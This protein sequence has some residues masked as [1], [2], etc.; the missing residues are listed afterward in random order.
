M[1]NYKADGWDQVPA[2]IVAS[3]PSLSDDQLALVLEARLAQR[4]HVITVN[5]TAE[6]APWADVHYFGDYLAVKH[7][8]PLLKACRGTWWTGDRAAAERHRCRYVRSTDRK[9][10]GD[11]RVH[12]NGNSGAQALNL[13]VL[14][15]AKRIVLLGFDMR[16]VKGRAHWF[17]QHPAPL[18]Q[19]QQYAEWLHKFKAVAEDA[20]AMNVE[21]TNCTPESALKWFETGEL[22]EVLR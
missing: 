21:V 11:E 1:N 19:V 18:V 5:N 20:H 7:Y 6:R 9:G 8:R 16:D 3:G 12:L 4:C 17:G 10:L 22:G 2:V 15:G 14:F 13:A